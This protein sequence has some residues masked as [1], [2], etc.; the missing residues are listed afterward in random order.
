MV[1]SSLDQIVRQILMKKNYPIHY[2]L[3]FMVFAREC[4]KELT[5]DDLQVFNEKLIPIN[6]TNSFEIPNDYQDYVVVGIPLNQGIRPLVEDKKM[7]SLNNFDSNLNIVPYTNNTDEDVASI[8]PYNGLSLGNWYTTHYDD[9]GSN[10]GRFFGSRGGYIDTFKVCPERNQIQ[11]NEA[12]TGFDYVYLKYLSDGS[13]SGSSTTIDS[14]FEQTISAYI[15]WQH[16]QQNR[17]YSLGERQVAKAEYIS[18][19]KIAR[20]RKS[21]LTLEVL[22]RI[23]N[24]NSYAAAR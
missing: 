15:D 24:K 23:I 8:I 17:T 11:L 20:A 4:L 18:Q 2:Y 7:T 9:Y 10:I 19:R 6:S 13:D 1:A 3:Q 12:L 16:K 5:F 22:K 21:G 14:Y